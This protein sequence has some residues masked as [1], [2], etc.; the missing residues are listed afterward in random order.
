LS[1]VVITVL[2]FPFW[3]SLSALHR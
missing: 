2:R 1:I 3:S